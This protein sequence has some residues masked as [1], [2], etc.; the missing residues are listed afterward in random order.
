M[1]VP[2]STEHSRRPLGSMWARRGASTEALQTLV[3]LKGVSQSMWALDP[4]EPV[5]SS[6]PQIHTIQCQCMHNSHLAALP[7]GLLDVQKS[8][9]ILLPKCVS[10]GKQCGSKYPH[11]LFQHGGM[12]A[13]T[14]H[15]FLWIFLIE[16]LLHRSPFPWGT[17]PVKQDT[18][19]F[20]LL[21]LSLIPQWGDKT[22]GMRG[23]HAIINSLWPSESP[24]RGECSRPDL[25]WLCKI[26]VVDWKIWPCVLI[27][28]FYYKCTRRVL[29]WAPGFSPAWN[30]QDLLWSIFVQL[31]KP[32]TLLKSPFVCM[33]VREMDFQGD[34]WKMV[35]PSVLMQLK[36]S[37]IENHLVRMNKNV[38]FFAPTTWLCHHKSDQVA[39]LWKME[40]TLRI[41][42][43]Y[44]SKFHIIPCTLNEIPW[45][46]SRHPVIRAKKYNR[47]GS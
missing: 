31:S 19:A 8:Q 47:Y 2:P 14:S 46:S 43:K 21:L 33:C 15:S 29:F 22:T 41:K 16:G 37:T 24:W 44:W 18:R 28:G 35:V 5:K 39:L 3:S 13:T 25:C 32:V 30:C 11:G 36:F 1:K 4:P 38:S 45:F 34:L 27:S 7:A 17:S 9:Q 23:S 6:V 20:P 42:I 10:F 12:L 26:S 40:G